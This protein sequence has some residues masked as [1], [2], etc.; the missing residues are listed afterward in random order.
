M[1]QHLMH[2]YTGDGKGKTTTAMG[3]AL[4]MLG[5]KQPVFIAQ[6]MKDGKSAELTALR[7]FEEAHIFDSAKLRGFFGRLTPE[8]QEETRQEHLASVERMKGKIEEMKPALTVL[9]ELNVAL[10]MQLVTLNAAI[11]LID[12]ALQYGDV[13]VTG[14]YAPQALID[15]A[16]YVSKIEAV[17]HPFNESISARK[18]I[19]F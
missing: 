15:K 17:K 1:S 13:A 2:V 11:S 4:R 3:L 18:G 10:T 6:F 8:Q 14:R 9:D 19:E 7:Q 5:H 16:D 12:C